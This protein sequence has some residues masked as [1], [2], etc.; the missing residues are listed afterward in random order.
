M[1]SANPGR[2]AAVRT[3]LA[4]EEGAHAEDV[5]AEVAPARGADRGLAWHLVQGVFRRRGAIDAGL[6]PFVKR[7]LDRLEPVVLAV[8]RMA[9]VDAHLSRTPHRAAVHQAV[10]VCRAVDAGRASGLVNAVLR[11]AVARPLPT[12][13][14]LDLPAWLAKRWAG[15]DGWV[16]RMGEIPPLCIASKGALPESLEACPAQLGTTPVKN[17]WVLPQAS[18]RIEGMDGFGE[19]LWWVMDTAAAAVADLVLAHTVDGDAVLDA[20]AAPGGKS[21]RLHAAGRK[22]TAVDQSEQRIQR[23]TEGAA[24]L[25]MEIPTHVHKWGAG[26]A[27]GIGTF[28]A[29][30]VDAPCT[31]LG[32]IRRHPEIRWRSK[33]SDAA[34]MGIRQTAIL[35]AAAEHVRPGGV[36]VYAVCSPQPEEGAAVIARLEGW[37]VVADW[38]SVPPVGDEDAHQAFALRREGE[39]R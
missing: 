36:L 24:R 32:T 17:A 21:F 11:K 34:A 18:G 12:D 27:N 7:D 38:S 31:G 4:V 13:P 8:L 30:L 28:D 29:V 25:N 37:S 16:Q 9:M 26:P 33:P 14:W 10:E 19:G 2:I 3:L 15:W 35:R 39:G 5:L 1:S 20:C 22:I 6:S 23:L